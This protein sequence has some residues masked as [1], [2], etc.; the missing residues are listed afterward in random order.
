MDTKVLWD[1][2]SQVSIIGTEW[3]QR[4]LPDV[5]VRPVEDLLGEGGLD[6]STAN[7]TEIPYQG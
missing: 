6:L 1:T 3:K 5:A 2:G 7:S 4:H